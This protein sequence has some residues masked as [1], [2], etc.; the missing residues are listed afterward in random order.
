MDGE[1]LRILLI[2]NGGREHAL[3]WKL[4]QSTQVEIIF[5]VPGNGGTAHGLSKVKNV[6]QVSQGDFE[7]LITF[8]RAQDVNLVVPGPEVP[9]V[10]GVEGFFRR[11]W[12]YY[13]PL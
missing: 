5:V 11:G 4:S 2:G 12:C 8:A 1:Q 6:P 13:T 7:G 10:N 3:A 9:L